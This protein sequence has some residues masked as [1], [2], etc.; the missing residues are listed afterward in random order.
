MFIIDLRKFGRAKSIR[1]IYGNSQ[2]A[3]LIKN[4][5]YKK[6]ISFNEETSQSTALY[7]LNMRN[8]GFEYH[9]V[10]DSPSLY[11]IYAPIKYPNWNLNKL[12]GI[13]K[14]YYNTAAWWFSNP[15]L[16][17]VPGI[18]NANMRK[19][20]Q[21]D[22]NDEDFV[23][24]AN[25]VFDFSDDRVLEE[26]DLLIMESGFFRD[27]M[28]LDNYDYLIF[29]KIRDSF[30]NKKIT[31]KLHPRTSINRFEK[32]FGIIKT[33]WIPWELYVVNALKNNGYFPVQTG[34]SSSC[35]FSDK[36][37]FNA[38]L[39]KIVLAPLFKGKIKDSPRGFLYAG[40]DEIINR[41]KTLRE[42]YRNPANMVIAYDIESVFVALNQWLH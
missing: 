20:D 9:N 26:T 27:G 12:L 34:I 13:D 33:T 37:L 38:E 32:D 25:N 41:Y 42:T 10:E 8:E 23:S 36:F 5:K 11:K 16:V 29:K 31:V 28:M 39:R 22:V 3:K 21:I 18:E 35:F 17:S 24:L 7:N 40:D 6:V 2:Q 19:L 1:L 15:E 4:I 14:P 30:P